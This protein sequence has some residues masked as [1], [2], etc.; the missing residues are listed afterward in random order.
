M[1]YLTDDLT[2]PDFAL[3]SSMPVKSALAA[4]FV[5]VAAQSVALVV[6]LS[7]PAPFFAALT[8]VGE[9]NTHFEHFLSRIQ[10]HLP[11]SSDLFGAASSGFI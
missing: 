11:A 10:L 9:W 2:L 7:L 1:N 8:P 3:R 6:W 4:L 5:S